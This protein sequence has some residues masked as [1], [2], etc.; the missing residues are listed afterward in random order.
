MINKEFQFALREDKKATVFAVAL[1]VEYR[2]NLQRNSIPIKA[3]QPRQRARVC[4]R[5]TAP[6]SVC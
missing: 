6:G 3:T 5:R 4:T 1:N 2:F